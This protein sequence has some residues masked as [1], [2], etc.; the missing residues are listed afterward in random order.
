MTNKYTMI[1][2]I[3]YCITIVLLLYYIKSHEAH[4]SHTYNTSYGYTI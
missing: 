2:T 1:N 3:Y 4:T